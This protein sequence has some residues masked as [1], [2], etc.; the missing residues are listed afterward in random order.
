[1][2]FAVSA[3]HDPNHRHR[4]ARIE[5]A[6]RSTSGSGNSR[7]GGKALVQLPPSQS[8][9]RS[10]QGAAVLPWEQEHH[11]SECTLV[12]RDRWS[13]EW[14][15]KRVRMNTQSFIWSAKREPGAESMRLSAHSFGVRTG[16]DE[17]AFWPCAGLNLGVSPSPDGSVPARPPVPLPQIKQNGAESRC[18]STPQPAQLLQ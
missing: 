16:K 12:Y 1:M 5:V 11:S 8:T 14:A 6:T 13:T 4:H 10:S 15:E 18:S 9:C 3:H 2:P 7:A 17:Y